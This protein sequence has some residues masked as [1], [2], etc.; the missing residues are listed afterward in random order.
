MAPAC[1]ALVSGY[2]TDAVADVVAQ[3]LSDANMQM[4]G[5]RP[6]RVAGVYRLAFAPAA[7]GYTGRPEEAG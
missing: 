6:G 1:I 5:A 7:T 3:E 2:R 4:H